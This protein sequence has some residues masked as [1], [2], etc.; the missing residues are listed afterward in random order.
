MTDIM[1]NIIRQETYHHRPIVIIKTEIYHTYIYYMCEVCGEV[2]VDISTNNLQLKSVYNFLQH[3]KERN[4][5]K[6]TKWR[7]DAELLN[8]LLH[9]T[10]ANNTVN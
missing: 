2:C 10:S 8:A 5:E 1:Y 7:S 4:V 3:F 6:V 9:T